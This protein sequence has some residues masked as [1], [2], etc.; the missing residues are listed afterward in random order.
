MAF[1][2]KMDFAIRRRYADDIEAI[3]HAVDS[4][5]LS[6][7]AIKENLRQRIGNTEKILRS[8]LFPKDV[9]SF[10]AILPFS[11]AHAKL[12][13]VQAALWKAQGLPP[14]LAT[15]VNP[16]DPNELFTVPQAGSLEKEVDIHAMRGEHRVAALN[17]ANS[18][19][20]PIK[21]RLRTKGLPGGSTPDYLQIAEV[22]WTDTVESRPVTAA[23][24]TVES[25]DGCWTVMVLPGLVQQVWLTLHAVDIADGRHSGQLVIESDTEGIDVPQTPLTLNIYPVDF[26]EKTT[27]E[28]GGWSYTSGRGAYGVT[29]KNRPQFLRHLQEHYVNAPWAN[30]SILMS[31]QFGENEQIKLDTHEMDDWIAQWPDARQYYI[32]MGLGE[33]SGPVRK[34]FAGAKLGTVEFNR[35]VGK[36][37]TAWVEHLKRKGIGPERLGIHFFD[38]PNCDSDVASIIEWNKALRAAQP[39]VKAWINPIYKDPTKGSGDLL[40]VFDILCPNR[41][42]WLLHKKK[43]NAFYL[44]QKRQGRKLQFYSCKGPA[45]LLDPY[46]YYRLQAWH[47]WKV[48]GTGSFFWAFGDNGGASSW[49]PCTSSHSPFTPLFIDDATVT[50]GK[51]MEAI[52]Q[53][54]QDYETL[55]MLKETLQKAKAAGRNDAT[56]VNA[57]KLL[58]TA[59]DDVLNSESVDRLMWHNQ[60][61]RTM[62]DT[63]RVKI[64]NAIVE[65]G[66]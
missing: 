29:A 21:V 42:M 7:D 16:W 3:R 1:K 36:W 20:Q 55:L 50:G 58:D 4:T 28:V 30:S 5:K 35:R 34:S 24:S 65:L 47:C 17:L 33:V 39:E 10:R 23:L 45:R 32:F 25:A 51:H 6:D 2:L 59:A 53:S 41:P 62:A 19:N 12:F 57:K 54:V 9:K 8:S 64:L 46:A 11:D 43:F 18:T 15:V 38:E 22:P 60:K 52:R 40:A 26:P 14:L 56:V 37:I 13:E 48:G 44:D 66:A 61:D 63:V 27:L 31:F 49:N